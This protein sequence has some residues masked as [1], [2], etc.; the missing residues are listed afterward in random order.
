VKQFEQLHLLIIALPN[1]LVTGTTVE[2]F[3][4]NG[5]VNLGQLFAHRFNL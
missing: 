4:Q 2:N 1:V 3:A 5:P